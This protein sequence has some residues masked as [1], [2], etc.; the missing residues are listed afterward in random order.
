MTYEEFVIKYK[1]GKLKVGVHK[2]KANL[3]ASEGYM[4]KRY[5]YATLFWTW[6]AFLLLLGTIPIMIWWHWLIGIGSFFFGI[7]AW[8]A[9]KKSNRDFVVEHALENKDFYSLC[10]KNDVFSFEDR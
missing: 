6:I 3:L 4:P 1:E 7:I 2:T 5:T 10:I 8:N 9:V